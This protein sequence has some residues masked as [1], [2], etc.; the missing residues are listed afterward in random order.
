MKTVEESSIHY[1]A[2]KAGVMFKITNLFGPN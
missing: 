2:V 1:A